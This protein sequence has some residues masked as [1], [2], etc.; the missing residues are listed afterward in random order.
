MKTIIV[1]LLVVDVI[2][3]TKTGNIVTFQNTFDEIV[4]DQNVYN[5][6]IAIKWIKKMFK[7]LV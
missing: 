6:I 5:V 7:T 3:K 1:V 2:R 4:Q